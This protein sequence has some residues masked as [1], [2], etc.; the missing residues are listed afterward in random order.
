MKNKCHSKN[1]KATNCK[2]TTKNNGGWNY[3]VIKVKDPKIKGF[4]DSY[5]YGIYEV[6][7]TNRKPTSWSE[8][9]IYPIGESRFE[10]EEDYNRMRLAFTYPVLEVIDNKLVR[11]LLTKEDKGE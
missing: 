4:D 2:H 9:P 11:D 5:S 8:N 7:Y 10:L 3:R 1:A 6:Y